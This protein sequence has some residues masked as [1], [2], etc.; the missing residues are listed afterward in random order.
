MSLN[1]PRSYSY[2]SNSQ[3]TYFPLQVTFFNSLLSLVT[4]A[5]FGLYYV[6]FHG[7]YNLYQTA[8]YKK[9]KKSN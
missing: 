9:N 7:L 2:S 4:D 6:V 1:N 3:H 5:F 8:K